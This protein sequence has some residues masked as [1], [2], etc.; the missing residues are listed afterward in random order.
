M[1]RNEGR[2]EEGER[3]GLAN[4]RRQLEREKYGS[5][6]GVPCGIVSDMAT[7]SARA[8]KRCQTLASSPIR[9]SLFADD[10]S[11]VS[12]M[13]TD[14]RRPRR[15]AM[16]AGSGGRY[17]GKNR[18]APSPSIKR[19]RTPRAAVNCQAGK[20]K[21]VRVI[22]GQSLPASRA[23]PKLGGLPLR[24]PV[25]GGLAEMVKGREPSSLPCSKCAAVRPK[26]ARR[27]RRS[28]RRDGAA[29]RAG[30]EGGAVRSVPFA[31]VELAVVPGGR[32]VWAA[33][34]GWRRCVV[35]YCPVLRAAPP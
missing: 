13:T 30:G 12:T 7:G 22:R 19:G 33:S 20:R 9:M 11:I 17:R 4:Q 35:G 5:V 14:L 26:G 16:Y 25:R 6:K 18:M 29:A 24:R 28:R 32:H 21:P 2:G 23:L 8:E 3:E 34:P 1:V 31:R 27:P 15:H 10:C